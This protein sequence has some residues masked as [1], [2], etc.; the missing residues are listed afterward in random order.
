MTTYA[1]SLIRRCGSCELHIQQDIPASGNTC[2][3]RYWTDGKREAPM[4]P[5]APWLVACPHCGA[6][7]WIDELEQVGTWDWYAGR[8]RLPVFADA[9]EPDAP[10]FEQYLFVLS[11]PGLSREKQRYA[12]IR[13][14]WAA[15]DRRRDESDRGELS[16]R[17]RANLERLVEL[18]DPAQA[19][20]RLMR[21]EILR[22]LGRFGRA[23]DELAEPVEEGLAINAAV[24]R[25]LAAACD[26]R[27]AEIG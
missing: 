13:A 9:T 23:L 5:D 22:E 12:R 17:E 14:W 10:S 26:P 25:T 3:A 1:P 11:R 19:G 15:N 24:I 8:P 21:A 18:L 16:P 20:D 4:L 2:G 7:A 6:L 27:V